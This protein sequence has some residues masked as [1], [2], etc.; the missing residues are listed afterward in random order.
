[1]RSD[2]HVI[3]NGPSGLVIGMRRR[4]EEAIMP[5]VIPPHYDV[6]TI[7]G[8]SF[9]VAGVDEGFGAGVETVNGF[10]GEKN[11][12]FA[13]WLTAA[14]VELGEWTWGRGA[15]E[16]YFAIAAIVHGTREM[17]PDWDIPGQWWN[18]MLPPEIIAARSLGYSA[19][20]GP[21]TLTLRIGVL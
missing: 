1:M 20:G 5:A 3:Q 8:Y 10:Y 4:A 14:Q 6:V 7:G 15:N 11:H 21:V 18:P 9:A 13:E 12:V 17:I 16:T 19:A 2:R